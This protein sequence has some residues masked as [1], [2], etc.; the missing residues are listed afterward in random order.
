MDEQKLHHYNFAGVDGDNG[1]MLGVQPGRVLLKRSKGGLVIQ[2]DLHLRQLVKN[3][4]TAKIDSVK[5]SDET[6]GKQEVWVNS[7]SNKGRVFH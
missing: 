2:S 3:A 4:S 7:S 1:V 6:V 5:Y